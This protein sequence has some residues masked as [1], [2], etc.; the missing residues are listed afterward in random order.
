MSLSPEDMEQLD[1]RPATSGFNPIAAAGKGVAWFT[2]L[3]A[4]TWIASS[5]VNNQ[6]QPASS[7]IADFQKLIAAFTRP[8]PAEAQVV[9]PEVPQQAAVQQPGYYPQPAQP[10]PPVLYQQP[11]QQQP[12]T[13]IPMPFQLDVT[14][15][16]I[17][18]SYLFRCIGG[19][20]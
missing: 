17:G 8:K 7:P 2:M 3:Y 15:Q 6:L 16:Q 10:Q 5:L 9:Q 13:T 12:T 1:E 11:P 14:Q 18:S 20:Q 19:V 4:A